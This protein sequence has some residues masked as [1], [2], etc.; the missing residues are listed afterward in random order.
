[1]P[2]RI[3]QPLCALAHGVAKNSGKNDFDPLYLWAD[4]PRWEYS[5]APL[6]R[7]DGH[8]VKGPEPGDAG[9]ALQL[10]D[11]Q[12]LMTTNFQN[13]PDRELTVEFWM[14]SL[15]SCRQGA[16]VS[17]ATGD[18]AEGGQHVW[19][20]Q[21]QQLVLVLRLPFPFFLQV[22]VD[23]DEGHSALAGSAE[24]GEEFRT[25]EGFIE[26]ADYA[27]DD[28]SGISATDGR[29]HH[30]AV[31]WRSSDGVT[32]LYDNGR[33]PLPPPPVPPWPRPWPAP[34]MPSPPPLPC[35]SPSCPPPRRPPLAP[36]PSS[37]SS[38][39]SSSSP[40]APPP[41][42]PPPPPPS[43]PAAPLPPP[44]PPTPPPLPPLDT[45]ATRR[46]CHLQ[47]INMW[48]L[49]PCILRPTGLHILHPFP[50]DSQ[51]D[52]NMRSRLPVWLYM[53]ITCG[54]ACS[55][56]CAR[57]TYE[58]Q[59]NTYKAIGRGNLLQM[60]VTVR[61]KGKTLQS[62]GTLINR[63]WEHGS[64]DF[65]GV[66][67][68]MR[69][70]RKARSADEIYEARSADEIYEVSHCPPM[71]IIRVLGFLIDEMRIWHKARSADEIYEKQTSFEDIQRKRY[72]L[73]Q[74][75]SLDSSMLSAAKRLLT[76]VPGVNSSSYRG[77]PYLTAYWQ[78][79]EA[80]GFVVHDITGNG[81]DLL[82][83]QPPTMAVMFWIQF[84]FL[85]AAP[86]PKPLCTCFL[87]I[88]AI[89]LFALCWSWM[90]TPPPSTKRVLEIRDGMA[91][92]EV[93]EHL[94]RRNS[95]RLGAV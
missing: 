70:W 9:T 42:P 50:H 85:I 46:Q 53:L 56:A 14:W 16:P 32:S 77:D 75:N 93:G 86:P 90:P 82:H 80:D 79:D 58:V 10:N 39:A 52:T 71:V 34:P 72:V 76:V 1:M 3:Y 31:T 33:L 21:L 57:S 20:L 66:I 11:Q 78:F 54:C 51:L 17:Y 22:A 59:C 2:H 13:W 38:S 55:R 37:S 45:C 87:S 5:T 68:E 91:G 63:A 30:I 65:Y 40:P 60:W 7:S 15:D 81:H 41:S 28:A 64:Q 69:I 84:D 48:P 25:P 88:F 43:L 67:D 27:D 18:Y 95:G 49:L 73:K 26:Y 83:V 24:S 89:G 4:A 36:P 12:V 74:T 23:E 62:G 44:S 19:N 29:W 61:A 47:T 6:T 8:R 92:C 35:V 94:R